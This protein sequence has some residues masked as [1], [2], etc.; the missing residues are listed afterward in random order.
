MDGLY[1]TDK[2]HTNGLIVQK[3]PILYT[4]QTYLSVSS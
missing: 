4:N 1:M 3:I 2:Q